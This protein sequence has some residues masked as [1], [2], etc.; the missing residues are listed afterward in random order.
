MKTRAAIYQ[1]FIFAVSVFLMRGISLIMLPIITTVLSPRE[2]GFIEFWSAFAIL[3]SVVV[4]FGLENALYVRC[5]NLPQ[6][7]KASIFKKIYSV[8]FLLFALTFS[9]AILGLVYQNSTLENSEAFY[10]VCLVLVSIS[11]ESCIA[12]PLGWLRMCNRVW[13]FSISSILRALVHATLVLLFV[14]SDRGAAGVFEAGAIAAGMQAII[15]VILLKHKFTLSVDLK[16][17]RSLLPYCLPIVGSGLIGFVLNGFDRWAVEFSTNLETLALYGIAAKFAIALCLLMQPFGMWWM[18]N[19][20][21]ILN[22]RNGQ[23]QLIEISNIGFIYLS[24]LALG[25]G[26]FGPM[27]ISA[28]MPAHYQQSM[29]IFICL[30]YSYAL[31]EAVE[32]INTGAFTKENTSH[33]LYINIVSAVILGFV[34]FALKGYGVLAVLIA[35]L[36][37]Q[38]ARLIL[39]YLV[40]QKLMKLPYKTA[41][42]FLLLGSVGSILFSTLVFDSTYSETTNMRLFASIVFSLAS[43]VYVFT[44]FAMTPQKIR[45]LFYRFNSNYAIQR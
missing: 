5:G 44:V 3:G 25:L 11:F 15:L 21:R 36:S 12:V 34:F 19:R 13:A 39:F 41:H 20:F 7:K 8:S 38:F 1:T 40:S 30:I 14:F 6:Y 26:I 23:D 33:Q 28:I 16:Y 22:S 27:V 35:V 32:L 43:V 9:L 17:F 42:I 10:V 31:K 18:P 24:A 4:S 2:I 29:G 45:Q 37:S